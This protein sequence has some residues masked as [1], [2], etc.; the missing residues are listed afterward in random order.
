MTKKIAQ[1]DPATGSEIENLLRQIIIAYQESWNANNDRFTT[2]YHL[3]ITTHKVKTPEKTNKD[4][5]YL[6]LERH[7]TDRSSVILPQTEPDIKIIHQEVRPFKSTKERVDPRAIWR[8][9]LILAC[10]ARVFGAGLEYAELLQ[11]MKAE[12]EMI[13]KE[14][15]LDLVTTDKMPKELNVEE[16]KYKEWIQKNHE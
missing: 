11:R 13:G 16:K 14:K 3:T 4:V 5:A 9:E 7:L 6:R 15:K 8:D 2:Q 10:L 12:K 1:I